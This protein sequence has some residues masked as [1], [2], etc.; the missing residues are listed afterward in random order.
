[1]PWLIID[2]EAQAID[3]AVFLV[4]VLPEVLNEAFSSSVASFH[5]PAKRSQDFHP[6]ESEAAAS[7]AGMSTSTSVFS[8]S[9]TG[10]LGLKTPVLVDRLDRGRHHLTSLV[11]VPPP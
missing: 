4:T 7:A 9:C 8:L 11:I 10:S 5:R 1:M 6:F 2:A 3:R